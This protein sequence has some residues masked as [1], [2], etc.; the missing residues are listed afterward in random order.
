MCRLPTKQ[1]GYLSF[2]RF[3]LLFTKQ[4][5]E[6]LLTRSSEQCRGY[7]VRDENMGKTCVTQQHTTKVV[8]FLQGYF[9]WNKNIPEY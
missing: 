4:N 3:T 5:Q 1:A 9:K 2:K 7:I 6:F 8:D